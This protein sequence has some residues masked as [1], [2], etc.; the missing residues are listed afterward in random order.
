MTA[1][2]TASVCR[3]TLFIETPWP[4]PFKQTCGP[5]T[6]ANRIHPLPPLKAA[7]YGTQRPHAPPPRLDA[8]DVPH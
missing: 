8:V 3:W 6:S 5:L 2:Q 1:T 7:G 4:P